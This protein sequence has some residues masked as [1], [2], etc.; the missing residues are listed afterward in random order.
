MSC[1]RSLG[2]RCLRLTRNRCHTRMRPNS[3]S[4]PRTSATFVRLWLMPNNPARIAKMLPV[5]PAFAKSSLRSIPCLKSSSPPRSP[6]LGRVTISACLRLAE[7][8]PRARLPAP[9]R[10]SL[11]SGRLPRPIASRREEG[12]FAT[13]F[14]RAWIPPYFPISLCP[15]F[16]LSPS[17]SHS[18]LVSPRAS[19]RVV[20][21]ATPPSE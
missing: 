11:V 7:R 18:L 3:R 15:K 2:V 20:P 5:N 10:L 17:F 19:P 12:R 8:P 13:R 21:I 14:G 4:Q 9:K 16:P 6:L 1:R